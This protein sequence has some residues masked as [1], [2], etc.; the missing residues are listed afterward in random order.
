MRIELY[1][2]SYDEQHVRFWLEQRHM[3]ET[4]LAELPLLGVIAYRGTR[5]IAAGFLRTV[6]GNFA[7]IDSLIS[8]PDAVG[9]VR[10]AALDAVISQLIDL[11]KELGIK[12]L[13]S[14]SRDYNTVKRAERHGFIVVPDQVVIHSLSSSRTGVA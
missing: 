11:A 5:A 4:L 2:A 7:M 8:N 13:I 10:S 6:E 9:A 14:T 3:P 12:S 1:V